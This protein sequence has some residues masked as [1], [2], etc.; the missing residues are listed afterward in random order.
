MEKVG[1]HL[2]SGELMPQPVELDAFD[3]AANGAASR[4]CAVLSAG[5][6]FDE[7][8]AAKPMPADILISSFRHADRFIYISALSHAVSLCAELRGQHNAGC[9]N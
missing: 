7:M 6:L 4:F 9:D 5:R 2:L 1:L 8:P 3:L